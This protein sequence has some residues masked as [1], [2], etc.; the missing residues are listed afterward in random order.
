MTKDRVLNLRVSDERRS[1]YERAAALEGATLTTFMTSAADER[2]EK[3]LASHASVTV[4][5]SV[6]DRLLSA[7]DEPPRP[8]ASSVEKALASPQFENK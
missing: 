2:V 8:L 3:V 5:S 6:F 1:S 4:G 7:L